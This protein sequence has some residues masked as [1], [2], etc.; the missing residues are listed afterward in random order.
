MEVGCM[1]EVFFSKD[2]E[3]IKVDG[4]VGRVGITEHAAHALGDVTFVELPKIGKQF[5]QF[6]VLAA[7]ESVKAASDIYAPVS[8]RVVAVNSSVEDSP[9]LVNESPEEKAWMAEMAIDDPGE[10]NKLMTAEQYGE[11]LK[12][13]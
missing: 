2:H 4:A 11:Y 7:I 9:E 10:L 13:L 5:K 6:D 3:W 8:G 1:S 12:T